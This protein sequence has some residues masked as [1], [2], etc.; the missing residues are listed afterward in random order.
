MDFKR[1]T[2]PQLSVYAKEHGI[3]LADAKTKEEKIET[4]RAAEGDEKIDVEVMGITVSVSSN[5]FDDFDIIE[6][7]GKLQDGNIFVFPKLVRHLFRDD[8][9]RI[10]KH[11]EDGEGKLTVTKAT[12]FFT[13][14]IQAV[15][16][17]N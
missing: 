9:A 14:V 12:E 13:G 17:K 3:D 15:E 1:M 7:F 16:A 6:D 10:R 8:F 5:A 4:I 2:V 11:L